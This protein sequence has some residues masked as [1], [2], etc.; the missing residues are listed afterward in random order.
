MKLW[1]MDIRTVIDYLMLCGVKFSQPRFGIRPIREA[2]GTFPIS[3]HE[4]V[5]LEICANACTNRASKGYSLV[6][7]GFWLTPCNLL[8]ETM[9]KP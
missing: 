6:Y 8:H 2:D 9:D 3:I 5:H 7:I 4:L 1:W